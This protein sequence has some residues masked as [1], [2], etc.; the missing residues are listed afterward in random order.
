[1]ADWIFQRTGR[2]PV[3]YI[4]DA[5]TGPRQSIGFDRPLETG[6]EIFKALPVEEVK[7]WKQHMQERK[8]G[9]L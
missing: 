7:R 3:P 1:M 5:V 2:A 4:Y 6:I 9:K 8:E